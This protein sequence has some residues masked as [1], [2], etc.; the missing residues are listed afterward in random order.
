[1]PVGLGLVISGIA[2]YGDASSIG[3]STIAVFDVPTAQ[4]LFQKA[5]KLDEI[6]VT[7]GFG[8]VQGPYARH[9]S[10]GE[11]T[12]QRKPQ[13]MFNTQS[14]ADCSALRDVL[15]AFP[16]RAKKRHDFEIWCEALDLWLEHKP[17]DPWESMGLI[18]AELEA[19]RKYG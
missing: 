2:T 19:V 16:L 12:T 17:G 1:M 8:K 3:A 10:P 9:A 6:Q 13:V 11:R 7:L 5:D 14:K 4:Q 18:K 15:Q